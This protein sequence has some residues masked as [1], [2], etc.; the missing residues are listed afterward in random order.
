MN[1]EKKKDLFYI[2]L[3][4]LFFTFVVYQFKLG[5][6]ET[7]ILLF[8]IPSVFLSFKL[9]TSIKKSALFSIAFSFP[10]AFVF[11]YICNVSGC[12]YE[13]GS[14]GI[15]ILNAYPLD[16]FIWGFI[17]FYFITIFYEYFFDKDK[18]KTKISKNL[19]FWVYA[20]ILLIFLFSFI[21]I[22]NRELLVIKNF[23]IVGLIIFFLIPII[24]MC[25]N[26]PSLI[27]KISIQGFWFF[28]VSVIYEVLAVH[29][30][31]WRFVKGMNIGWVEIFGV[32]F[33][34]EEF[35]FL[36]FAVPATIC[37]YEFLA[38]DKN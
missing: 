31:H 6:L 2:T 12:W 5:Y 7:V 30:G 28:F 9:K 21:Y 11:D 3:A 18:N 26:Y 29:L 27:K 8:G 23:Y 14:L 16:I 36:I 13:N 37:I 17:Y 38:D 20:S 24:L 10:M 34:L 32:G 35:L 25:W 4:F 33:A 22:T 19:K 15:T 1:K